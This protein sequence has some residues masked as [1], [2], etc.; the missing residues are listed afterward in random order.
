MTRMEAERR[1]LGM[2]KAKLARLAGLN[3]STVN[4]ICSGRL[5][6]YPGQQERLEQ[7]LRIGPGHL[8][9]VVDDAD[10]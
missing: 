10:D 3:A 8:L 7:V 2:T 1:R 6:P 4:L 5:V 9:E